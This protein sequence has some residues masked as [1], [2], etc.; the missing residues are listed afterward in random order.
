RSLDP[1]VLQIV[2]D[3]RQTVQVAAGGSTEVRFDVVAKSIGRARVQT[4]VR[5]NGE[6]DAFEDSIPVEITVSPESVAAYGEAAPDAKQTLAMP[7][8]TIPGFGGLHVELSSTALVGLSEGA[9]YVVEYPYGC[10][11]QRA[12]RTF[13]LAEAADLG[14]AFHLAG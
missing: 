3:G 7:T 8:G 4:T 10:V 12:S 2:G 14:D 6:E 1:E 13:V 11:E 5:L 9:R